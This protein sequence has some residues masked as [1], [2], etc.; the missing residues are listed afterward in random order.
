MKPKS[1]KAVTTKE[2]Q[3][4]LDIKRLEDSF[5]RSSEIFIRDLQDSTPYFSIEF[6]ASFSPHFVYLILVQLVIVRRKPI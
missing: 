5:R 1:H 2:S 4:R 6:A 3:Q